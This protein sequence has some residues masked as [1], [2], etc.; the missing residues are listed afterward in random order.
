MSALPAPAK[1]MLT[2]LEAANYCGFESVNGFLAYVEVRP[3]KFGKKVCYDR[4]D[5]DAFLDRLR[6]P[7]KRSRIAELAGESSGR[8][9]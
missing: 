5:L 8:G 2:T 9:H 6:T 3:V 4:V 7:T 1:R